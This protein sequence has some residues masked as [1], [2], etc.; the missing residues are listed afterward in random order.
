MTA[1]A[2]HDGTYTVL[3]M[4]LG[5][6]GDQP[7]RQIVDGH[8]GVIIGETRPGLLF[9][10]AAR[11]RLCAARCKALSPAWWSAARERRDVPV[12]IWT[13]MAG[14]MRVELTAET[15]AQA[16][17]WAES[18]DGWGAAGSKPLFIHRPGVVTTY[19]PTPQVPLQ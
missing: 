16:L 2:L 3:V 19:G 8:G 7:L 5:L 18:V 10:S 6:L 1:Q 4:G 12:A 15:A 17:A 11:P 9:A 14:R 13:L